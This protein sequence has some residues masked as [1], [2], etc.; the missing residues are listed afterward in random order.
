MLFS[1]GC[2]KIFYYICKST[3][4]P[5]NIVVFVVT[6]ISCRL[7]F[8][9]K[10]T[11]FSLRQYNLNSIQV[12]YG[13][14]KSS[15]QIPQQRHSL[16]ALVFDTHI[17]SELLDCATTGGISVYLRRMRRHEALYVFLFHF[18]L[19]YFCFTSF[20]RIRH[21]VYITLVKTRVGNRPREHLIWPAS[22]FSLPNP[23][24]KI[25]SKRSSMISRNLR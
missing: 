6:N 12:F 3:Q 13:K 1:N 21:K 7:N 18:I 25:A 9:H 4:S 8:Q 11:Q 5:S 15:L 23:E 20:P 19:F 16:A 10:L 14:A 22:E 17:P 24:Y 2:E